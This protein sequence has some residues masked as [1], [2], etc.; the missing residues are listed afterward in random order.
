MDN[1]TKKSFY[2]WILEILS[3]I[4]LIW[5]F[6][7]ILFY[8]NLS[9]DFQIPIHYDIN[10]DIDDW[11]SRYFLFFIPLIALLLYI[12][13]SICGKFYTKFNYPIKVT[14]SNASALYLLGLRLI[15]H[16]KFLITLIFAYISNASFYLALNEGSG[17]NRYVMVGLMVIVAIIII[18][19]YI[20]M[21]ALRESR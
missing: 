8:G 18:V 17:L 1:N 14:E 21:F 12:G 7:P 3:I 19:Y 6:L 9:S 10:G 4:S 2:D 15:R 5:A 16:L 20:K 13:L 11:G